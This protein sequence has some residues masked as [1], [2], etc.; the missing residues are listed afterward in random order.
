MALPERFARI[1]THQSH[2]LRVMKGR[3]SRGRIVEEPRIM[4]L[5]IRVVI[6]VVPGMAHLAW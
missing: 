6:G 4:V 3:D 5:P 2:L 1:R